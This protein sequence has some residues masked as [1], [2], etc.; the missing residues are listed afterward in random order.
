MTFSENVKSITVDAGDFNLVRS[1]VTGGSITSVTPVSGGTSAYTI[2]A[3]TGSGSGTLRL[4]FV[5]SPTNPVLDLADKPLTGSD[6][7]VQGPSYSLDRTAPVPTLA[8]P[9][10]SATYGQTGWTGTIS[11]GASD[12]TTPSSGVK[13][14]R[15]SIQQDLGTDR[16]W[17]GTGSNF[18]TGA[19]SVTVATTG[20][21]TLAFPLAN[22]PTD[23]PYIVS[24]TAVDNLGNISASVS[25]GFTVDKTAPTVTVTG[26]AS[27]TADTTPDLTGNSGTASNDSTV[28][29][30]LYSG[31]IS[32]AAGT[33]ITA[34]PIQIFPN[35][36][37]GSWSVMAATLPYATYTVQ[38]SQSDS[39]GNAGFSASHVFT[40]AAPV[41]TFF[42]PNAGS[43]DRMYIYSDFGTLMESWNLNAANSNPVGSAI[44][45][46]SVYVLDNGSTKRVFQYS[47]TGTLLDTSRELR[48]TSS[49]YPFQSAAGVAID[50]D[51]LWVVGASSAAAGLYR[52]SLQTAFGN[53]GALTASDRI[54]LNGN[55]DHSTGLA[56]DDS[57]LYVT[58]G[59]DEVVYR[60]RR[61]NGSSTTSKRLFDSS[62]TANDSH[63]VA[64]P[65][66]AMVIGDDLWV[67]GIETRKVFRYNLTKSGHLFGQRQR[68]RRR[69]VQ[70]DRGEHLPAGLVAAGP[71]LDAAGVAPAASRL[72]PRLNG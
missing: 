8:F 23:G 46:T 20:A 58:D 24:V 69:G 60:Y 42:V 43:P 53:G 31:S 22:F 29:V 14:V 52:Y 71:Q 17:T 1:G 9:T 70:P 4:D 3:S 15:V 47:L 51:Q 59:S 2:T 32:V 36:S 34:T 30:K 44:L 62:G 13:E 5:K 68:Q 55:N 35:L 40:V 72:L 26:P 63:D 25:A 39:L 28:T 6:S 61:S 21:W 66:G 10:T 33:A 18:T 64:E 19:K 50:G 41:R 65:T 45:G 27:P 54:D 56:I 16:Y 38:A 12:S 57:Y 67:V 7:G 11:G 48:S 37:K 49:S